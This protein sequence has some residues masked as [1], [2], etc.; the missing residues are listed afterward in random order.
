MLGENTGWCSRGQFKNRRFRYFT[1]TI[2]NAAVTTTSRRALKRSLEVLHRVRDKTILVKYYYLQRNIH[3][4]FELPN[5][6]N[7]NLKRP[8]VHPQI[9]PKSTSFLD[10]LGPRTKDGSG[11]AAPPSYPRTIV[12]RISPATT[13]CPNP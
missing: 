5:T 7:R 2:L 10:R 3:D 1:A 8:T 9:L 12:L 4:L 13:A 6:D 11:T